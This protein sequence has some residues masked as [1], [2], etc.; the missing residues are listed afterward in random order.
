MDKMERDGRTNHV[1]GLYKPRDQMI[2]DSAG[3]FDSW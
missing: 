3:G 2:V 1:L